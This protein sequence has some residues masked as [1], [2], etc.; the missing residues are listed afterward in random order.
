[1]ALSKT[2]KTELVKKF[3]KDEKDTGSVQVQVALL[4]NRIKQ[5]TAHLKANDK[6]HAARRSLLILVGHRKSLLRYLDER[7]HE[8][9]LKLIGEL[10]LRK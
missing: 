7:D 5:L 8:A 6:D 3:G 4:T 1:M 10:G 9:Y 2:E